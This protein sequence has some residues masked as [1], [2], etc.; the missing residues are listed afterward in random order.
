MKFGTTFRRMVEEIRVQTAEAA[1]E[2]AEVASKL[3]HA[4]YA[5][6]KKAAA[7]FAVLKERAIDRAIDILPEQIRITLDADYH[8]GMLSIRWPGHGLLHLP[9][10][11]L[12]HRCTSGGTPPPRRSPESADTPCQ[13]PE[14]PRPDKERP[15]APAAGTPEDKPTSDFDYFAIYPYGYLY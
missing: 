10:D 9:A 2:R 15:I 1:W 5:T 4:T 12:P 11:S 3:R 7:R 13:H 14:P 6:D 8:I